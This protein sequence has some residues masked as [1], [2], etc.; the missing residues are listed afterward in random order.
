MDLRGLETKTVNVDGAVHERILRF[1]RSGSG[2]KAT[3]TRRQRELLEL[4]RIL[5]MLIRLKQAIRNFNEAQDQY[6]A[7]LSDESAIR[8]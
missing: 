5:T 8:D 1:K 2:S 7:E 6:H 4:R 3:V